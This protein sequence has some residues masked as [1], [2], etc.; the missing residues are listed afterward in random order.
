MSARS[1][2]STHLWLSV[3]EDSFSF[4]IISVHVYAYTQTVTSLIDQYKREIHRLT[5]DIC[6]RLLL[7]INRNRSR[8]RYSYFLSP[9]LRHANSILEHSR[10]KTTLEILHIRTCLMIAPLR[11]QWPAGGHRTYVIAMRST[12]AHPPNVGMK[13]T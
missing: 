12:L 13:H 6:F 7:R 8:Q 9:K 3:T 1:L 2:S 4:L 5:C 11:C 10:L